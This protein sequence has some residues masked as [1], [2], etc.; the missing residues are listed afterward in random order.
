M[1]S[2]G[3]K[4]TIM[5][6]GA[7]P[8]DETLGCGGTI[9]KSV[10]EGYRVI[11]VLLTGGGRLFT[12]ALDMHTDPSPEEVKRLRRDETRSAAGILGVE[13]EDFVFLDYENGQLTEQKEDAIET[14]VQLLR[15]HAPEQV[16]FLNEYEGHPDHVAVNHIVR[17]ACARAGAGIKQRQYIVSLRY[18]LSLEDVPRDF[19]AVDISE[20][21]PLKR[22]AVS[23]F[24]SHLGIISPKQ[25]KPLAQNFDKYL[26]GEEL[27]IIDA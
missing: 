26:T 9:A 19:T 23:Q 8:D 12:H 13:K 14:V 3:E 16:W 24:Q 4:G 1:S 7:H 10:A 11:V 5:V 17:E 20:Y 22:E 27:F 18:G 21:V 15:E 2:P 6:V 25:T